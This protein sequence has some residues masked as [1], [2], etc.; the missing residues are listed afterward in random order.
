MLDSPLSLRKE[1]STVAHRMAVPFVPV[2]KTGK[3]AQQAADQ[4]SALIKHNEASGWQFCHLEDI[5]TL[6]N[7]G[8]IAALFG[9][10]T[11]V[12]NIQVAIFEHNAP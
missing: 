2:I 3:E 11:S 6:R 5:T 9:N 7:N 12:L 10:P 8:C 4:L 1:E